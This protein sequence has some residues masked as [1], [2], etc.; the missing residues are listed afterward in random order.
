MNSYEPPRFVVG[1]LYRK[2][3]PLS[4]LSILNKLNR[5]YYYNRDT[6]VV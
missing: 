3:K 6:H 2:F 4:L 1:I 5:L